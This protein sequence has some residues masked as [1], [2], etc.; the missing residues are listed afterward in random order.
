MPCAKLWFWLSSL[1]PQGI[2]LLSHHCSLCL[3]YI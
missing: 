3:S 2:S 1:C